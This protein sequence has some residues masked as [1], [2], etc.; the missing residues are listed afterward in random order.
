MLKKLHDSG[1]Q[2]VPGSDNMAAFTVHRELA[3]YSEAG[4]SNAD[5]LKIATLD[6]AR[7]VGVAD[8]TG[9]IAVGKNSDMILID[10]NP[11]QDISAIRRATLVMK[12]DTL[13]RP[14]ELYKAVGVKPFL[15]SSDF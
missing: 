2:L 15:A 1:I 12:G 5:V 9:S 13:Y 10:G 7:V 11:L 14:D 8:K 4:I 6:S 3:V